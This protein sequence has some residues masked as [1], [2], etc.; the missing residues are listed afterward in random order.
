MS[1]ESGLILP[2]VATMPLPGDDA[3]QAD[4]APLFGR[5]DSA[6]D[7]TISDAADTALLASIWSTSGSITLESDSVGEA[8][9]PDV[10]P[11]ALNSAFTDALEAL[12]LGP[13]EPVSVPQSGLAGTILASV[14]DLIWD[15]SFAG[16]GGVPTAAA[17][18]QIITAVNDQLGLAAPANMGADWWPSFADVATLPLPA[19]TTTTSTGVTDLL[20]R[21]IEPPPA[22]P[23]PFALVDLMG[24]PLPAES[25]PLPPLPPTD[26]LGRDLTAPSDD[27]AG[28]SMAS[29]WDFF[30]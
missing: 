23:S 29:M 15:D 11:V 9:P 7:F 17:F 6:F 26:L 19:A 24:R 22:P 3:G 2:L 8:T 25:D 14:L 28:A 13:V 21:D 5:V 20:G 27:G 18:N 12:G 16:A 1:M 30:A 4:D 10:A